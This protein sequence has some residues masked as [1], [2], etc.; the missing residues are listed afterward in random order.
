M[1]L[2]PLDVAK[3]RFLDQGLPSG[4]LTWLAGNSPFSI[5]NTSAQSGSIFQ[6]AM[7]DYRSVILASKLSLVEFSTVKT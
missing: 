4:K 2:V 5:G 1:P 7:L 3:N 6:P